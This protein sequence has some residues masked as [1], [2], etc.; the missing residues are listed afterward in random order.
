MTADIEVT[1]SVLVLHRHAE[2]FKRALEQEFPGIAILAATNRSEAI[3]F[4]GEAQV[5]VALDSQF[6]DDL[7]SAAPALQWIHALTSGTDVIASLAT[8]DRRRVTIT[9]TRGIHG[10]QMSEIT[11]MHMLALSRRLP[12]M[13]RN[14]RE[15]RW[16]RWE[17]P[18]L[19]QK[20]VVILGVG[21]IAEDMARHFKV[22]GMTV[23]G[24]SRTERV[25]ANFDCIYP[26]SRMKEVVARADYFV[27]LAPYSSDTDQI[28]D[29][30]VLA[31]MK[32]GAY[33][34]NVSRGGVV[35]EDALVDAL[36]RGAIAGAGLDVFSSEPLPEKHPLWSLDNVI[37]TPR[38]GGMS[39]VY[40]EQCMP[41]LRQNLSAFLSG[42]R[43][44]MINRVEPKG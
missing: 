8:L 40:V 3:G 19:W 20:T 21:A 16:E 30:G 7:I 14:Q 32:P 22:F 5:I 33:L 28:V 1:T 13:F 34:V 10:P 6:R 17:Q 26:R 29:A 42:D 23:L 11:L 44:R 43:A 27:V 18:L 41:Q 4:A 39:D 37:V 38:V 36:R 25:L 9:T 15:H 24:I 12:E 35:D 2:R 31:A